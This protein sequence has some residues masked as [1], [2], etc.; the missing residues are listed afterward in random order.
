MQ[1]TAAWPALLGGPFFFTNKRVTNEPYPVRAGRRVPAIRF[2]NL[3][4]VEPGRPQLGN[5]AEL[6][7]H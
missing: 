4:T 3:R 5:C 1:V 7:V 2:Y 6:P